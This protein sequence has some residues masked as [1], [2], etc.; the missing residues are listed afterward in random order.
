MRASVVARVAGDLD[1]PVKVLGVDVLLHFN[2]VPSGGFFLLL[3]AGEVV[4]FV[5]EFAVDLERGAHELHGGHDFASGSS[6]EGF[7]VFVNLLR[8]RIVLMSRGDAG[9]R[10][11]KCEKDVLSFHDELRVRD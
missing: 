8:G 2:H 10:K 5:A 11:R 9:E 3:V 4:G 6:D 1:S 7:D